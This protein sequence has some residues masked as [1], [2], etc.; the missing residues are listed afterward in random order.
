MKKILIVDDELAIRESLRM[1]LQQ[2]YEVLAVSSGAEA[3]EKMREGGIDLVLLDVI[4]PGLDGIQL[5]ER[6]KS[7]YDIP[8]IMIT[9]ANTVKTAVQAMRLGAYDYIPKPFDVDEIKIVVKKVLSIQDLSKEVEY[10]RAE[11]SKTYGFEN[12]IGGTKEMQEIFRLINQIAGSDTSVL[13]LGE[14]GT[15]KELVARAIHFNSLRKNKPFIPINCAAIPDT[16][17]ESE[18]FGHERGA[19][20]G[21]SNKRIGK[22]EQAHSGTLFLDE[23]AELSL[24]TQ[25]KILRFLQEREFTRVGGTETVHVDVRLITA[26]NQDL[27]NAIKDRSLREDFY[28]RINI[29]PISLPPLRMRR[30]D[31]PLLVNHFIDKVNKRIKKHVKRVSEDLMD[32]LVNYEWPGNVRELENLMERMITLSNQ[33]VLTIK[34]LPSALKDK[35]RQSLMKGKV[36]EGKVSFLRA[37]EEFEKEVILD[38]LKKTNNVQT[39]AAALLGISRRI[40][41]Y[42]MDK[43]GI[44]SE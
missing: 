1:I 6:M 32:F 9:A 3:L 44:E 41:K 8:V 17:I 14:S 19:F 39:Q 31:I 29:I 34:D 11:I 22:F 20:T 42:K 21:A 35:P 30:D 10:L 18:L 26:T 5:L 4:M 12:L 15:G 37:T 7:E 2:D 13:I 38:A 27:E 36:V 43:L 24:S 16:L 40:L 25:A 23:I 28:Y 33:K